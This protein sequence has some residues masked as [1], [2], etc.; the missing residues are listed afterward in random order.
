MV[1]DINSESPIILIGTHRSGTSWLFNVF[2]QHP[3]LASWQEPRYVWEWG[4]NYKKDDVLTSENARPAVIKHIRNRFSQFVEQE[5]KKRLF[6]KTPNNCLRLPFINT[7]YPDAKIIHIVRD[8]RAVFISSSEMLKEGYY[9]QEILTARLWEMITETPLWGIPAYFPPMFNTLTSKLLKRPLKYWGPR[10]EGWQ[11]WIK[12]DSIN[13]VLAKQWAAT[14]NKAITDSEKIQPKFYQRFYYEELMSKPQETIE[15]I[16]DFIE[17]SN[18][19]TII[20]EVVNTLDRKKQ[21]RWRDLISS[22]ILAE[23]RPYL[24]PTINTLGYSW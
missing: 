5:Q 8:G 11:N 14:M 15:Q 10:P 19:E 2:S 1:I 21:D 23:I 13:V 12:Q 7:I 6:E 17:L 4:N 9:R 18:G 24:E 3:D 16:L 22:E 20:N